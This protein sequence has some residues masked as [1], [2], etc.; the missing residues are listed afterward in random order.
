ALMS[1]LIGLYG[2]SYVTGRPAPPGPAENA[3]GNG[4]LVVHAI[5]AGA[6][7]LLGP[8]QFVLTT[9]WRWRV[10]HRWLGRTYLVFCAIG[11][12][13][14]L[15]LATGSSAGIVARAGF[16][17]LAA[18]W[19]LTN[20]MGYRAARARDF[21]AHRR[22]MIRSFALTFAAV[23][24]RLYLVGAAIPGVGFQPLYVATSW[25]CWVPNLIVAELW[26]RAHPRA[27]RAI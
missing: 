12:A 11:G 4:W 13:V 19:L 25:A 14:G 24:L 16:G 5:S 22:W 21:Q 20:A 17:L 18:S 15:L 6:A 9:P 3:F 7:L 27:E 1:A 10:A 23:T 2:L 8:W 26:L